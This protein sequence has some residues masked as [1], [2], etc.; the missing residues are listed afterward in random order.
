[1][2]H[3]YLRLT[4]TSGTMGNAYAIC[5]TT[6]QSGPVAAAIADSRRT[7]EALALRVAGF[8]PPSICVAP[9]AENA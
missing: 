4:D 8:A 7:A 5:D 1:M 3:D 6:G 9:Q 2:T